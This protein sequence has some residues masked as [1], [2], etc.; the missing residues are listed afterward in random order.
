[1]RVASHALSS[2]VSFVERVGSG[3]AGAAWLRSTGR[4]VAGQVLA[5]QPPEAPLH[6]PHAVIGCSTATPSIPPTQLAMQSPPTC[7][8]PPH[9][10]Q[11]GTVPSYLGDVGSEAHR[12]GALAG[13]VDAT[14]RQLVHVSEQLRLGHTRVAH[15][16]H[17]ELATRPGAGQHL[18]HGGG[19][20]GDSIVG[21]W[22]KEGGSLMG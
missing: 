22:G 1:M 8:T 17:V 16:Q 12:R 9:S 19:G 11:P 4:N 5:V 7:L 13:G 21:R 2:A 3:Q 18:W 20:G 6:C 10:T 14:W 15:Q